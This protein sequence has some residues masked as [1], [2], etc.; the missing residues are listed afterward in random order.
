MKKTILLLILI[1]FASCAGRTPNNHTA[2]KIIKHYFKKYAKKYPNS[3][4]GRTAVEKIE[5]SSVQENQKNV[6][7]AQAKLI[8][9]NGEQV[10]ILMGFLYKAPLGWRA[11]GWEKLSPKLQTA[12]NSSAK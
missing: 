8:L 11:Q 3:E 5:I 10:P 9:S 12:A 2:E 6:A 7:H 4:F 1:A